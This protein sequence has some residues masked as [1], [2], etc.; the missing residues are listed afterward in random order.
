[1]KRKY[2]ETSEKSPRIVILRVAAS[3][4]DEEFRF[5]SQIEW[6]DSSLRSSQRDSFGG[7]TIEE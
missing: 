2:L 1:M 5:S 4:H 7:M 6:I 3:R